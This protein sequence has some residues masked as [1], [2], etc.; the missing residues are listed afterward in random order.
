V[1][2]CVCVCV[3]LKCTNFVDLIKGQHRYLWQVILQFS[4]LSKYMY[5]V[6]TSILFPG[7]TSSFKLLY[8]ASWNL[9][10]SAVNRFHITSIPLFCVFSVN[11]NVDVGASCDVSSSAGVSIPSGRLFAVP[12]GQSSQLI[13]NLVTRGLS[14]N[15]F[16]WTLS[17]C[18]CG[19]GFSLSSESVYSLFIK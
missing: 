12:V 5:G 6:C 2:V 9:F 18:G 7:T 17:N 11:P 14:P 16:L 15:I 13:L 19:G 4:K 1:C 8:T 3:S 10:L